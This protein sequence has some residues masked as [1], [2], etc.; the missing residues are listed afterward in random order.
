[1]LQY[2]KINL[3]IRME[4]EGMIKVLFGTTSN[5]FAVWCGLAWERWFVLRPL[6]GSSGGSRYYSICYANG[7]NGFIDCICIR[8]SIGLKPNWGF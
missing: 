3:W 7:V 4:C 2:V 5:Y 8:L 1:M 6:I